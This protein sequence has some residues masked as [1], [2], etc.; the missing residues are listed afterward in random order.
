MQCP[1][2]PGPGQKAWNPNGLVAEALMT[3]HTSISR[4]PHIMAIS[5]TKAMFTLRKVFSR[6][7]TNSA[8]RGELTCTTVSIQR[9]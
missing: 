1:P 9:P 8:T 2:S 5:L 4:R 6:S 3:S 7:L